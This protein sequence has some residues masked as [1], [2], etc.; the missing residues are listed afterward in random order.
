MRVLTVLPA[1]HVGAAMMAT[2]RL[3]AVAMTGMERTC[4]PVEQYSSSSMG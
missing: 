4:G 3:M 1:S 2:A